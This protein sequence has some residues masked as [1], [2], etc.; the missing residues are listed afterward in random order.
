[1]YIQNSVLFSHKEK[2]NFVTFRKID[3]SGDHCVKQNKS[4]SG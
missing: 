2:L 1:M 4:D 3:G